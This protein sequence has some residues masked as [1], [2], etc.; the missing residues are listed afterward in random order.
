MKKY[1]NEGSVMFNF[2]CQFDWVTGYLD[3]SPNFIL[4]IPVRMFLI[5]I[6]I[7]ICR[8]SKANY[9]P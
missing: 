8:L 1:L 2:M 7:Q 3:I 4:G 9:L 5:E 6:N